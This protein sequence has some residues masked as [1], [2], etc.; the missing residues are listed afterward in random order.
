MSSFSK[1]F[2]QTSNYISGCGE[3][4]NSYAAK[5]GR[6]VAESSL[7]TDSTPDTSKIVPS[8]GTV[9]VY[10]DLYNN[11]DS[12]QQP[13]TMATFS[14]G[15]NLL[16]AFAVFL[17][18]FYLFV[19]SLT[20]VSAI[21]T[22]RP[23]VINNIKY[24][25]IPS[26]SGYI[27]TGI[28]SWYGP[29]FH[30]RRTSNGE[31]YDMNGPTAAHKILPMNTMLLVQNLENGKEAVVRVNDRGPFVRGRIIDLS[32]GI[33]RQLGILQK[34][35]AR[36]KITALAASSHGRLV[37]SPNFEEGEFYVQIGSFLQKENALRLQ[38]RFADAGH[39]TVIKQYTADQATYFRVQVFTGNQLQTAKR[40][41]KALL[42]KG[43][44]GAFIV[45]R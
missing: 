29:G 30:G 2:P 41:E 17:F 44:T 16:H 9:M 1:L 18:I 22:Q 11:K 45:A 10:R 3:K 43:Y 12:N 42:E 32:Y 31:R 4:N 37:Q 7:C 33:A 36:V 40:A 34:G 13:E 26:S 21:P 20:E 28:A 15:K 23:Y 6:G 24:Y 25:P 19:L 35:T 38:K 5:I 27:D 39:P 14:P 8:S